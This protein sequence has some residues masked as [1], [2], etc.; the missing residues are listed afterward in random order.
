M[1]RFNGAFLWYN[2]AQISVGDDDSGLRA[3]LESA[4]GPVAQLD[5]ASDF[6]SE[7]WGFDSLRGRHSKSRFCHSRYIITRKGSCKRQLRSSSSLSLAPAL[8]LLVSGHVSRCNGTCGAKYG[9][10][11]WISGHDHHDGDRHVHLLSA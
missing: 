8:W 11:S 6:G 7:G 3:V 2:A 1:V 9:T 10:R 4:D 5:R